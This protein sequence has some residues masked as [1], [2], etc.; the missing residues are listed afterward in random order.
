MSINRRQFSQSLALGAA[1]LGLGMHGTATHSSS[2]TEA[3]WQSLLATNL[4]SEYDY[5]A[6]VEGTI[7]T[8]LRGCLYRN[9]PGLFERDGF[10]KATLLDGDGMIQAIEIGD[11][12]VRYRNRF[13]RT[14]K[15]LAE[16]EAGRFLMPTWT[17]RAPAFL[18]NFPGT[19]GGPCFTSASQM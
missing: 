13:V 10:R 9:G 6:E 1:G 8:T 16:Q 15:Y 18:D 4:D 12:K 7:P 11:G 17:T 14:D 5:I 3:P 2:A 19:P